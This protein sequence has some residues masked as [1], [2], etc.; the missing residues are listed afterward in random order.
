L[1]EFAILTCFGM[2]NYSA[3]AH[4]EMSKFHL[5]KAFDKNK[6]SS[7]ISVPMNVKVGN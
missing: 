4:D 6:M 3:M 5:I 1:A 2:S 7:S